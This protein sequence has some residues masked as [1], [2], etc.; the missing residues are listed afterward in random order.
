MDLDSNMASP[1]ELLS[2]LQHGSAEQ[3]PDL[4][5]LVNAV[6]RMQSG[7]TDVCGNPEQVLIFPD[8]GFVVKTLNEHGSKVF[9]NVCGSNKVGMPGGWSEG[10]V[11]PEVR[12]HL[13][14][15]RD[16]TSLEEGQDTQVQ[17]M[18]RFPLSLSAPRPETDHR[19]EACTVMDCVVHTDIL[20][21]AASYRP[22]KLFL[23]Q[24]V[25][26][27]VQ[28][29]NGM[30]LDPKYKLPKMRYKGDAPHPQ[31]VRQDASQRAQQ[32][33]PLVS[34][35]LPES[36]GEDGPAF[37]LIAPGS[38]KGKGE[39]T[40]RAHRIPGRDSAA[41]NAAAQRSAA[42]PAAV[43]STKGGETNA[44]GPAAGA[45][46]GV[47]S[48]SSTA[49]TAGGAAGA[50]A[51]VQEGS[52]HHRKASG[53][54][55]GARQTGRGDRGSKTRPLQHEVKY[56]GQPAEAVQ[57]TVQLPPSVA[58]L[59]PDLDPNSFAVDVAGRSV[60]VKLSEG[61]PLEVQ[62]PFF[63]SAIGARAEV[64]AGG[65]QLQLWLPFRPFR[66]IYNQMQR[67]APLKWGALG[68]N[69]SPLME[70]D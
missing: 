10:K 57:V 56:V 1:E 7:K 23:T 41:G 18:L 9:I 26:G 39:G 60:R 33:A 49:G 8:P 27:W 34:E 62:L 28:Q 24:L 48:G 70:L 22:L 44:G 14:A 15:A 58:E 3:T 38:R 36:E 13:E 55:P 64:A 59:G 69:S 42:Q 11:P 31:Y 61:Q 5:D 67:H 30:Q 50:A 19:G 52:A 43:Q 63:V 6:Q 16:S 35:V 68:L 17:E 51:T 2:M 32:G 20:E 46:A 21:Q 4:Q 29:K 54:S 65:Q 37:P 45:G 25:L 40:R 53:G 66:D 47:M 12:Q